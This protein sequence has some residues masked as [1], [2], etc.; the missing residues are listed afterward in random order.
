MAENETFR[1]GNFALIDK[2][3]AR[4]GFFGKVFAGIGGRAKDFP[5]YVKLSYFTTASAN[6]LVC[7]TQFFGEVSLVKNLKLLKKY[8]TANECLRCALCI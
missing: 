6:V 3:N 4:T 7:L 8:L 1:I 2:V 5:P